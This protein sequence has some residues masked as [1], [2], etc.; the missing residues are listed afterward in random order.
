MED[1]LPEG[2]KSQVRPRGAGVCS[3]QELFITRQELLVTKKN[4]LDFAL[5]LLRMLRPIFKFCAPRALPLTLALSTYTCRTPYVL[6]LLG[7]F[8]WNP[9]SLPAPPACARPYP[10]WS[11]RVALCNAACASL[12]LALITDS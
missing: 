12:R 10:A 9:P 3:R 6:P 11:A 8:V 1:A 2:H 7:V 4:I 5:V